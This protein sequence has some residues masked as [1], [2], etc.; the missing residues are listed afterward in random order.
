V[1][2]LEISASVTAT[3]KGW[4]R[5]CR[6]WLTS[7]DPMKI[8]RMTFVNTQSILMKL[9]VNGISLLHVWRQD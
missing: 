2:V 1:K 6:F 8:M 3:R 5:Y 7:I 9:L 4:K